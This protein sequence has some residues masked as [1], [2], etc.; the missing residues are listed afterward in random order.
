M[1]S[2][3]PML[4]D[5]RDRPVSVCGGGN[6]AARKVRGLLDAGARVTVISPSLHPSIWKRSA[7]G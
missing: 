7:T 5:L 3:Y 1:T 4:L 6:V 2:G